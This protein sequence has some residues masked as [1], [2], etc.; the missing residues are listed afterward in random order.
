MKLCLAGT[1]VIEDIIKDN[2]P[3]FMLE[4]FYS[5]K[6]WQIPYIKS[7]K[8]FLLD[9]G[10]FTFMSSNTKGKQFKYEDMLAYLDK[11]IDFINKNDVD[12]FFE[13][14]IDVIVGYDRVLDLR[15]KLEEKTGKKCIPVFHKNRGIN[16][17]EKMCREYDYVA[18][19]CTGFNDSQWTKNVNV[20]KQM[21]Q[22]ARKYKTKV[23]GLGYTRGNIENMTFYSTDS[24]SWL[25][26]GR[27]GVIYNFKNG[28]MEK[29]S[30]A[31]KRVK[32]YRI[33]H[34]HNLNEWIKYQRYLDRGR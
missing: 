22:I 6:D 5:I 13:L 8:L 10:A 15:R 31:N 24:T 4:S 23:H 30:Y 28:K 27:F 29:V 18:I 20:L 3:N 16:E 34:K 19:G 9:S 11:Y 17:W 21:L 32:D 26:G 2:P 25:A 7:S 14:D 1:S 33:A 12:Y